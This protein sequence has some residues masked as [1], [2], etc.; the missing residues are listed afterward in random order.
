MFKLAISEDVRTVK[1]VDIN[2]VSHV[3]CHASFG[4]PNEDISVPTVVILT[5]SDEDTKPK[6]IKNISGEFYLDQQIETSISVV[7]KAKFTN[8]LEA[9]PLPQVKFQQDVRGKSCGARD[10]YARADA[11]PSHGTS[12]PSS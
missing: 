1:P 11:E 5:H 6:K 12:L 2:K 10:R 4:V 3:K 7:L 9:V 8:K